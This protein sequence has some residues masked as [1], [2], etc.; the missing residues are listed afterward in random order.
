[1]SPVTNGSPSLL[2]QQMR[3]AF[4]GLVLLATF[5]AVFTV[6]SQ[7]PSAPYRQPNS[8]YSALMFTLTDRETSICILAI[9]AAC[10]GVW[11]R[12]YQASEGTALSTRQP[13]LLAYTSS[14]IGGLIT[15][16]IVLGV[17]HVIDL[18]S[19]QLKLTPDLTCLSDL[20]PRPKAC[21][22]AF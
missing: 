15:A 9:I 3:Q 13:W 4:L 21:G 2:C 14:S 5:L 19:D 7:I 12:I 16:A 11:R 18:A 10:L 22:V 17:P 6:G 8:A 1:M 20:R